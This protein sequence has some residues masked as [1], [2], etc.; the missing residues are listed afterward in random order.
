MSSVH[1]HRQVSSLKRRVGAHAAT[2]PLYLFI[3][4]AYRTAMQL[5]SYTTLPWD[6]HR[7][8]AASCSS[9]SVGRA[10]CRDAASS[11]SVFST[12]RGG[13]EPRPTV[14]RCCMRDT[15]EPAPRS[16]A[17][18]EEEAVNKRRW[19]WPL[20]LF[21][22]SPPLHLFFFAFAFCLPPFLPP[23]LPPPPTP[24]PKPA[25]APPSESLLGSVASLGWG[26]GQ[27]EVRAREVRGQGEDSGRGRGRRI[28]VGVGVGRG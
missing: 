28:A 3:C 14:A 11:S 27:T 10:R 1:R 12:S 4:K 7:A 6:C 22:S 20:H 2:P 13:R 21:T 18:R 19:G 17:H 9:G 25:F 26:W 8:A 5:T 15:C 24:P 23:F 16:H